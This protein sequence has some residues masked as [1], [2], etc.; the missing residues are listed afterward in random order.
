MYPITRT[1]STIWRY[2]LP[3]MTDETIVPHS[4]SRWHIH[5]D[6][7]VQGVGF[8][9]FIYGLAVRHALTGWVL[10]SSSGVDIEVQG[11]NVQLAAF[12]AAI[13]V[14][15]PPLARIDRLVATPIPVISEQG[16]SIRDSAPDTGTSLVSPDV[17]TC[18]DCLAEILDPG[19]RRY[20]YP[21][22]NCT[23]CGPRYTIIQSMPY[24]RSATTMRHFV[25]C[26]A[27]QAEYEDP[28]NR[29]F[30]AQPNACPV[31][32]PQVELVAGDEVL[33]VLGY[34]NPVDD[35]ARTAALLRAGYIVA[36][37]GLGG[38]HIACDAT[39]AE[40]VERLRQRKQ[41]PHKPF[42]V[43]VATLEEAK[44]H[45]FVSDEEAALLSSVGAPIVLLYRRSES[46]IA[47]NVAP[48][49]PMLGLMLPYTPLHHILLRDVGR[50]LVMTSGNLSDLPIITDNDQAIEKLGSIVDAFLLHNRR[51][52]I[53]CDDAVWWVDRFAD[54]IDPTYQ[55]LRRSRG[56]AP[57]PIRL[58]WPSE[59]HILAVG[60]E[61]KN[62]FCLLRG[63]DAFLSQHIGEVDS[64]ESLTYFRQA[65]DHLSQLFKFDPA[66]LVCD[67]HPG[68]LTSRLA[69][70]L[71]VERDLP[72]LAVQHHHAH[73]ACCLAENGR[74]G[75]VVGIALDGTGYGPDGAIW[76]G[77][78]L[79]ASLASYE[80][81]AHLEYLPLPG[82]D[83]AIR[84]PYRIA[85]SYLIATQG[86]I[87]ELPTLSTLSAQE[88]RIVSKQVERG[89]NAPL[90]S[91]CGRLFDAVSALTG[92]CRVTTFEAQAAIA[93]ELAA[94]EANL[95]TL[96]PYPFSIDEEG[97]IRLGR[98]LAHIAD[99]VKVGRP[100]GEIAAA[101]HLSLARM[102]TQAAM[103]VR[104]RTGLMTAA[105][106]GG[107]FQNRLL[108]RLVRA[109]LRAA[110]FEVLTH[111]Q[112][113]AND[114]G[115]SL[116]QAVIALH[117]ASKP[118]G[119]S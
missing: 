103:R 63:S 19:N 56:D 51:I 47:F 86:T 83:A 28:L 27:C 62:T 32:G 81:V 116:G 50:P 95:A 87:P 108:L 60:A 59:E 58:P 73:I 48:D 97:V 35:I 91:S 22:T 36:I 79:V 52:H 70:E 99:D 77:E 102:I 109:Q 33:A 104:S 29:R 57:Y 119:C 7:V 71:A 96:K 112:T 76:G 101:F 61:M 82:G 2:N 75:P 45:C 107:V 39:N 3:A 4:L 1:C 10:N 111:R 84:K 53:G 14:E 5:I 18:P 90:T 55:P 13:T 93:L 118:D 44:S 115:L 64:L 31:C 25:M 42:A 69:R 78:V 100:V 9:P 88:R 41:R 11:P 30:H 80:R 98:M 74:E 66:I 113:P 106:S 110:G 105:L 89:V 94:R 117:A 16:F 72:C 26:P 15:A 114:G 40:A 92:M 20:R 65:L 24:D 38:F 23:N 8:R 34:L 17:A 6:G 43:M 21:F 49:N 37:K 46:S 12:Q 85:W 68:Y 54:T 67:L